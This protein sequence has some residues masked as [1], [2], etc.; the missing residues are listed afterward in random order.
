MPLL[1]LER[2]ACSGY[3]GNGQLLK[4]I[5]HDK[6]PVA[7]PTASSKMTARVSALKNNNEDPVKQ[8]YFQ[9][10]AHMFDLANVFLPPAK[11]IYLG[12]TSCITSERL[13]SKSRQGM[14]CF[15][16][17]KHLSTTWPTSTEKPEGSE[18]SLE[19]IHLGGEN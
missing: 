9:H 2:C 5:F 4:K 10:K 18:T 16:I 13:G 15:S 8:L 11:Q 1:F 12:H 19:N 3:S 14:N 7:P 6:R 17:L